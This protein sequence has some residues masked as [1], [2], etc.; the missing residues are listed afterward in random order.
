[1][2]KGMSANDFC[3]YI[4]K[5]YLEERRYDLL[6]D[7]ISD[8]ISVIGTGA[9]EVER[10]LEEFLAAMAQ[11]GRE[12]NGRF[13]IRDQWY[14]TTELSESHSLVMG[15]L[16]VREN[17]AD[18]ILYDMRFRFTVVLEK[19]ESGWKLL[20]IHQSIPD[21][22]QT[23]DEFF[24]HHVVEQTHTEVVYNLRHD[25]LTGLLNRLYFKETCERYLVTEDG[26]TFLMMDID[27]FKQVNDQYGHPTGDKLLVSFSESLKAVVSPTDIA[28]RI[29]GD[30]FA[31]FLSNVRKEED[32]A[33][34][35]DKLKNDWRER[36]KVLLLQSPVFV[37]V[38]AAVSSQKGAAYDSLL[39][40]ADQLLYHAKEKKGTELVH[41]EFDRTKSQG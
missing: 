13:I 16:T 3:H 29:G 37:S 9:H 32:V 7:Y 22:N 39:N 14:Q 25:S 6:D 8:K 18:G 30:E 38:G 15:E 21:P 35:I 10:N 41:W 27:W 33:A 5:I 40:Q 20:H 2:E 1:M 31:I 24:P 11:E 12:W 36:Q 19:A 34:F 17:A 23:R 28:G 26:G 4:W